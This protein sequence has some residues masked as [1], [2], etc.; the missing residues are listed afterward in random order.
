MSERTRDI[1]CFTRLLEQR[2]EAPRAVSNH[3]AAAMLVFALF[4][5]VLVNHYQQGFGL[6]LVA[7]FT[8]GL[9][10]LFVRRMERAWASQRPRSV[11][12]LRGKRLYLRDMALVWAIALGAPLLWLPVL[13]LF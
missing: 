10:A 1:S 8:T 2:E 7:L 6:H 11:R 5:L 9:F 4:Q 3:L 12:S 13:R